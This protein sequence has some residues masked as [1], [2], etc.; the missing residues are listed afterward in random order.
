MLVKLD[1]FYCSFECF[2]EFLGLNLALSSLFTSNLATAHSYNCLL[3]FLRSE[4][5]SGAS[6]LGWL[7]LL[8]F[9]IFFS[10]HGVSFSILLSRAYARVK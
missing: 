2:R 9:F 5:I 6:L 8:S 10:F 7:P 4:A 1:A 3:S